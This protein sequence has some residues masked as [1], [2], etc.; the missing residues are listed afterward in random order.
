MNR[1]DIEETAK[2]VGPPAV[3]IAAALGVGLYFAPVAVLPPPPPPAKTAT[4]YW[5]M[6][7]DA[8]L[9]DVWGRTNLTGPWEYLGRTTNMP[10]G[11]PRLASF[12]TT[13]KVMQFFRVS[14]P[15]IPGHY[16]DHGTWRVNHKMWEGQP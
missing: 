2:V 10:T 1:R 7:T 6:G 14:H 12:T 9:S 5:L 3:I 11:Q 4:T 8:V 16:N 13:Q 15:D